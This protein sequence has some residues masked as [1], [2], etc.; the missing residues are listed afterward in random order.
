MRTVERLGRSARALLHKPNRIEQARQDIKHYLSDPEV[1]IEVEELALIDGALEKVNRAYPSLKLDAPER[2]KEVR[3][4]LQSL[5]EAQA[6]PE[7]LGKTAVEEIMRQE[8][9]A[10]LRGERKSRF[11][12][13]H[14]QFP[15]ISLA[16]IKD[17]PLNVAKTAAKVTVYTLFAAPG[18]VAGVYVWI[19]VIEGTSELITTGRLSIDHVVLGVA[20][21]PL[22]VL[23]TAAMIVAGPA[24]LIYNQAAKRDSGY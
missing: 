8:A 17:K 18:P 19:K 21:A 14:I 22:F 5:T 2:L 12:N 9:V 4:I 20:A 1:D 16:S 10:N 23:G 6:I 11:P 3:Q 13:L 15:E 7:H 24:L